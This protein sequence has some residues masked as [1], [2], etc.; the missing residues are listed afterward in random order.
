MLAFLFDGRPKNSFFHQNMAVLHEAASD[1]RWKHVPW[2]YFGLERLLIPRL[3]AAFGVQ[4]DAVLAYRASYPG[5][6]DR[7]AFIPT[8][9]DPEVFYPADAGQRRALRAGLLTELG[10]SESS[11]VLI[12]V[13][14]LDSQKDP[15][16]LLEVFRA[17]A[18]ERP[19]LVL[20]IVGGGVLQTE[21]EA[22]GRLHGLTHRVALVGPQPQPRVAEWLRAADL[23]VLSSV[24]EGMPM[25]VLEALGSGLPV[26]TM[27][28]GEV[29]RVVRPGVNGEIA[30]PRS[31]EALSTAI[32]VCLDRLAAYAGAPC[33]EAARDYV[34]E[35]VLAPVYQTYRDLA[36]RTGRA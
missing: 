3:S 6:A 16:C 26:A 12:Y 9:M 22:Y 23:F 29:R 13:G 27:D 11:R 32:A 17:L 5:L 14:R 8:W 33:T 30:S 7:I 31:A 10:F 4:E 21:V 25:S 19:E 36:S 28:V 1:I 15:L 18:A 35:K 34:P 24:Y 20:V 2:L